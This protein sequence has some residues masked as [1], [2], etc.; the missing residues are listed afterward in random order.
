M[1]SGHVGVVD[2]RQVE[3]L[4]AGDAP[5]VVVLG[6]KAVRQA[7]VIVDQP[8]R[9]GVVVRPVVRSGTA[10]DAEVSRG[11]TEVAANP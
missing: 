7:E 11:W 9:V 8:V 2:V 4:M 3:G 1:P 10:I 5:G 6:V